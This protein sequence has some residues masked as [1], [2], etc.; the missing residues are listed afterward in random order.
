MYVCMVGG[1][2]FCKHIDQGLCQSWTRIKKREVNFPCDGHS[3]PFTYME[4][5]I[6]LRLVW[7]NSFLIQLMGGHPLFL[8]CLHHCLSCIMIGLIIIIIIYIYI[9]AYACLDDYWVWKWS[10]LHLSSSFGPPLHKSRD[11]DE[12]S[13]L[14]QWRSND[15][16]AF[17]IAVVGRE[18]PSSSSIDEWFK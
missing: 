18:R 14:A 6:I 16:N 8:S 9:Y 10:F 4:F 17:I 13:I 1:F 7:T 12:P 2:T 15:V 5:L 3:L 11:E